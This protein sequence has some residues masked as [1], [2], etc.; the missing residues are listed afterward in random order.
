[1]TNKEIKL[2]LAKVALTKCN[3]MTSGTLT[4]S[5]KNL[6][7]WIMEEPKVESDR[8][9]K[10]DSDNIAITEVLKIVNKNQRS[11]SGIAALL[12]GVFSNNNIKTVDD[13]LQIG[14][15]KFSRYRNVG[16]K[17][18]AALDDALDELGIKGW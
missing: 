13:L 11:A 7:E 1:M 18:I 2:E 8:E 12:G 9:P 17:S 15:H 14:R 6:Y 16:N 3:F 4:E 10:T 5:I